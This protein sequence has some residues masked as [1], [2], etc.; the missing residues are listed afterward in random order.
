M[1][2]AQL[3][4]E[5]LLSDC[6]QRND[7]RGGPGG[8]HRNK[9][10][11]AVIVTHVP[12]GITGEGSERR[13]QVDNRRNAI[14]R[15]RLALATQ[16]RSPAEFLLDVPSPLWQSRSKGGRV[17]CSDSHDDFPALLAELLDQLAGCDFELAK[18]AKFFGTTNAQLLKILRVH[19]PA[20]AAV[21]AARATQG[22]HRLV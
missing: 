18:T 7:R 1:H 6:Q 8:Q 19:P 15:L 3:R 10:E 11:T 5:E 2:P 9:V 12:S 4:L 22:L 17:H 14:F 13:S 20:L 16:F 21:N